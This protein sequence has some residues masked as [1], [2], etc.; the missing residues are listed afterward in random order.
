M[1]IERVYREVL[2]RFFEENNH[3][4]KVRQLAKECKVS[5]GLVSYALRPLKRMGAV[6]V[7]RRRFEILDAWKIMLYWC[8]MRNL[9]RDV[10]Y[11]N[12]IDL[13]VDQIERFLPPGSKLTAYTGF[14]FR[15][16]YVPADYGEVIVYG[17]REEF[18]RRFGEEKYARM[19]NL[20]VLRI[21]EHLKKF[22]RVPLP[23]IYV[24]LWNLGTWYARE[25]LIKLENHLRELGRR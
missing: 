6:Q 16:G 17:F 3:E 13:S 14:K 25:F 19:P 15:F 21:D 7:Y 1:K 2:Y 12:R 9:W 22:D 18:E 11:K 5:I 23:Q 24:D 4:F 20:I 10:I 8:S